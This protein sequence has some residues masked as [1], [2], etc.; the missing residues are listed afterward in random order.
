MSIDTQVLDVAK[1]FLRKVQRSGPEDVGAICPFHTKWDGTPEN[2]PSFAM[3]ITTGLWFCHSCHERGNFRTFLKYVGVSPLYVD[4][5]YKPLLEELDKLTQRNRKNQCVF[6]TFRGEPMEESVLGLFDYTPASLLE[7][8]FTP[9]TLRRFDVGFDQKNNRVT[10]P[11][12]DM[13][14]RLMGFSGRGPDGTWP[15]YKIYAKEEYEVWGLPP[16][17]TDRADL[18]WNADK[19]Y[20]A[21]MH[22]HQD[23][24]FV[25]T[26][27]YKAC[28]WVYQAGYKNA[29]A[30]QGS[31]M[32]PTQQKILERMGG[33][34]YLFLDN[35]KA[36]Y[37]GFWEVGKRLAKS[38]D[39]RIVQYQ[40]HQPTNLSPS[41]VTQAIE[42]A[43][44]FYKWAFA[45]R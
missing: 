18:I 13:L 2:T 17:N 8:G 12:R 42:A 24:I 32:S 38:L 25:L 6:I 26:E 23:P 19:V 5:Y 11:L 39:V 15:R 27:G 34:W 16:R 35:D 7:E 21:T 20:P 31:Y 43:P 1:H 29:L 9:E 36:G 41:E 30:L 37:K 33:T 44:D 14:G 28:M 45:G 3:S 10:Y 22:F 4:R 40:G